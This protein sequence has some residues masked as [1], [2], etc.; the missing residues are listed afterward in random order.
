MRKIRTLSLWAILPFATACSDDQTAK[1]ETIPTASL[2]TVVQAIY[3]DATGSYTARLSGP[4]VTLYLQFAAQSEGT[5]MENPVPLTG[6]YGMKAADA[7]YKINNGAW[8]KDAAGEHPVTDARAAVIASDN[9]CTIS[10]QVAGDAAQLKFRAENV[11]FGRAVATTY[12]L[13]EAAGSYT[14]SDQTGSYTLALKGETASVTV[15]LYAPVCDDVQVTIPDGVYT[16]ASETPSGT[17]GAAA[18]SDARGDHTATSGMCRIT[19]KGGRYTVSGVLGAES[20]TPVRFTYQGAIPFNEAAS[21]YLFTALGGEWTMTTDRW[22]VYDKSAKSWVYSDTGDSFTMSMTGIPQYRCMLATG[23][24]DASFSLLMGVDSE[25]L[26]IPCNAESNPVAQVVSGSGTYWMF[27]TLYDPE[28]GYFMSGSSNVPMTLSDDLSQFTITAVTSESTDSQTGKKTPINYEY[29]GLVGQNVSTGKYS[30]FS[31]WPFLRL[32]RFARPAGGQLPA[33][34]P[35][36]A[37]TGKQPAA[38]GDC[39]TITTTEE[40]ILRIIPSR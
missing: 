15:Q 10:G 39:G 30:L 2:D 18:W 33:L 29:F 17:L 6:S 19:C 38:A 12:A 22:L 23:L 21:P 7:H 34:C 9:G 37:R 27:A 28:T 24:F 32:P 20:E 35:A 36:A 4:D 14:A 8:W 25:G 31:N 3:D 26:F 16:L 1:P 11:R 5:A 13:T 40:Q